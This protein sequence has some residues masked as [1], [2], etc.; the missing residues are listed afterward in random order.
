MRIL[1]NPG[2]RRGFRPK[3]KRV[4]LVLSPNSPLGPS[5][6][7]CSTDIRRRSPSEEGYSRP[8]SAPLEHSTETAHCYLPSRTTAEAPE[9]QDFCD[10]CYEVGDLTCCDHCVRSYH[11]VCVGLEDNELPVIWVCPKCASSSARLESGLE[12]QECQFSTHEDSTLCLEAAADTQQHFGVDNVSNW[13]KDGDPGTYAQ[14]ALPNRPATRCHSS[15]RFLDIDNEAQQVRRDPNT[16]SADALPPTYAAP[17]VSRGDL[18]GP[19]N[20]DDSPANLALDRSLQISTGQKS[21]ENSSPNALT[22]YDGTLQKND[23]FREPSGEIA[24]LRGGV[25]GPRAQSLHTNQASVDEMN[26]R[27]DRDTASIPCVPIP[28]L[29]NYPISSDFREV[30]KIGNETIEE[31]LR[32]GNF[33]HWLPSDL[34][35]ANLCAL[36]EVTETTAEIWKNH[37]TRPPVAVATNGC[38]TSAEPTEEDLWRAAFGAKGSKVFVNGEE[39]ERPDNFALAFLQLY[40]PNKRCPI[41][42]IGIQP[43]KTALSSEYLVPSS[44]AT[45]VTAHAQRDVIYNL[46]PTYSFVDLHIDYGADGISKTMGECEKYWFLFPPTQRNLDL[47]ASVH[48]EQGRLRKL[49]NRLECGIIAKTRSSEALYIPSG[50]IHATCTTSGGFL[51]AKDFVTTR[52]YQY[53]AALLRSEYFKIFDVESREL[54][55]KWFVI[56]LEV[57]AQYQP[58]LAVCEIWVASEGVLRSLTPRLLSRILRRAKDCFKEA[59]EEVEHTVTQCPCGWKRGRNTF[60]SHW[61]EKHLNLSHA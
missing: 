55:M 4:Q 26:Q 14:H 35:L 52:T 57:A 15:D 28:S 29:V 59:L 37:T 11:G 16:P 7:L 56:S 19:R 17:G 13:L 3:L 12:R 32:N 23:V 45:Y 18:V 30:P 44:L 34:A 9:N 31:L 6:T 58:I 27:S 36:D 60:K 38:F 20:L 8:L 10:E 25:P 61:Q 51:V 48:G 2:G 47:L 41:S 1:R 5:N 24:R 46:T 49:L 21:T 33:E 42:V 43:S 22:G 39:N 40:R 54:C 53:I 50:C